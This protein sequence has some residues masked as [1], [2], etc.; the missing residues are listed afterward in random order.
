MDGLNL[1]FMQN[2]VQFLSGNIWDI[3]ST[4]I[5]G[6]GIPKYNLDQDGIG[7]FDL[8]RAGNPNT[9]ILRD[10]SEYGFIQQ[11][12]TDFF[13]ERF[14]KAYYLNAVADKL[15]SLV[16]GD[17]ADYFFTDTIQGCSFFVLGNN[18]H[19]AIAQHMNA[20]YNPPLTLRNA[21]QAVLNSPTPLRI[22]Y[23]TPDYQQGGLNAGELGSSVVVTVFGWRRADGWHF[24]R[25]RRINNHAPL[26]AR[27]LDAAPVEL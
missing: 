19:N 12:F 9:V 23:G 3:N 20:L 27:A 14:I 18:R 11:S 10:S 16:L 8:Y 1:L 15:K 21:E 24:Y 6:V 4:G 17:K 13:T 26:Q 5:N 7:S 22:S 25:R 2:P